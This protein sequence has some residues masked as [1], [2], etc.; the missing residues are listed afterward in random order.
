M[1]D[2]Y[3]IELGDT[4]VTFVNRLSSCADG[5]AAVVIMAVAGGTK[6]R[7]KLLRIRPCSLDFHQGRARHGYLVAGSFPS[8]L[9]HEVWRAVQ[10]HCRH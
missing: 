3:D 2:W 6:P 7:S 9:H 4:Y 10:R 5:L 1:A 8:L